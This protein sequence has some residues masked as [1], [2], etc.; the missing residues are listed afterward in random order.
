MRPLERGAVVSC[1]M[2][3]SLYPLLSILCRQA[4]DYYALSPKVEGFQTRPVRLLSS[5]W[6]NCII[7]PNDN[8]MLASNF[9]LLPV[10]SHLS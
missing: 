8:R 4:Q 5:I 7:W 1:T 3:I 2:L 10:L 6:I 9:Q